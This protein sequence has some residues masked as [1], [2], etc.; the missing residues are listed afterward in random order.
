M[1]IQQILEDY[2]STIFEHIGFHLNNE[3]DVYRLADFTMNAGKIFL[4][5]DGFYA[6]YVNASGSEVWCRMALE[7]DSHKT[8]LLNIDPHFNGN[9][10]W[11]LKVG[12]PLMGDDFLDAKYVLYTEDE[13]Q[14]ITA[15]VMGVGALHDFQEDHLYHFQVAMI[16]HAIEFFQNEDE[17]REMT[18]DQ[19]TIPGVL[20][21]YGMYSSM[22]V[23]AI[24]EEDSVAR[25][26]ILLTRVL[27]HIR[28]CERRQMELDGERFGGFYHLVAET[29]FGPLDIASSQ[30]CE[31]GEMALVT[32]CL[33]AKVMN[34]KRIEEEKT[35]HTKG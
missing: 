5:Q 25:T 22:M 33:S 9:H 19:E 32:G 3:E 11:K 31:S 30:G 28:S 8:T 24:D 17:Y 6:C 7:H 20:F 1:K 26:E 14:F 10:I 2:M 18:G 13:K 27:C 35:E 15:R 21:P 29:P 4:T 34:S 23:N 16:P 12:Q